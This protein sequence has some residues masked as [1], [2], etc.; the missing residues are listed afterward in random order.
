MD[1]RATP[2]RSST[3]SAHCATWSPPIS[4]KTLRVQSSLL[5]PAY[6]AFVFPEHSALKKPIDLALIVITASPEWRAVE[7]TY[8]LR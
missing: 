6:M 7:E 5:A 2:M 8:F 4:P 3:A 1:A